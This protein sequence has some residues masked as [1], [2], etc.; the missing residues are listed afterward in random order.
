MDQLL[1]QLLQSLESIGQRHGE[2]HDT[3]CRDEMREAV[4]DGFLQPVSG[5]ELPN[6]FGLAG[7][8]ANLRVKQALERYIKAGVTK[9]Q[10]LGL[11]FHDRLAALQNTEVITDRG[12][13]YDCFF[14]YSPPDDFT[15]SGEW[16]GDE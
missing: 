4:H 2:I 6:D 5:Y 12:T 9:A 16:I 1:L 10:E 15:E 11:T 13:T 14:G 8:E 3:V 7:E